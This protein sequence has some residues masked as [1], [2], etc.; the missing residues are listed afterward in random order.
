MLER[1]QAPRGANHRVLESL[2]RDRAGEIPDLS[3]SG[4]DG[5]TCRIP[6]M[7]DSAGDAR[8]S[9]VSKWNQAGECQEADIYERD[10]LR[11]ARGIALACC[12]GFMLWGLGLAGCAAYRSSVSLEGDLDDLGAVL[13][14]ED[15]PEE[16][17]AEFGGN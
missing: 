2:T 3:I 17:L 7:Q 12:L 9:G 13:A 14:E 15:A 5:A 4:D 10:P 6:D 11:P 1:R 16:L 8:D